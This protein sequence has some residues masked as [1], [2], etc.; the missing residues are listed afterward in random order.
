MVNIG[1]KIAESRGY[2]YIC[3]LNNDTVIDIDF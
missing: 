1:I 3:I 2:I